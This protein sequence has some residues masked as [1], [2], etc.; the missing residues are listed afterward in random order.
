MYLLKYS[1]YQ[2]YDALSDYKD[3]N[4]NTLSPNTVVDYYNRDMC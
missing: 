2:L 4:I 3:F 1:A